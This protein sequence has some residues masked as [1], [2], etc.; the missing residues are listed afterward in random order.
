MAPKRSPKKAV[1]KTAASSRPRRNAPR[2]QRYGFE[3]SRPRQPHPGAPSSKNTYIP[4]SSATKTKVAKNGYKKGTPTRKSSTSGKKESTPI[5]KERSPTKSSSPFAVPR[6]FGP[7]GPTPSTSPPKSASPRKDSPRIKRESTPIKKESS[8]SSTPRSASAKDRTPSVE[9]KR[10]ASK[11]HSP[12]KSKSPTIPTTARFFFA[13]ASPVFS[14]WSPR[15]DESAANGSPPACAPRDRNVHTAPNIRHDMWAP[16]T[17]AQW[18][19]N[20]GARFVDGSPDFEARPED[21]REMQ[22]NRA[23]NEDGADTQLMMRCFVRAID[24]NEAWRNWV[25]YF[26]LR[27][28][29][30][31]PEQATGH[32]QGHECLRDDTIWHKRFDPIW[33]KYGEGEDDE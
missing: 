14:P 28:C 18:L 19:Q 22:Y 33:K 1:V 11:S 7:F 32:E 29:G 10:E 30:C 24:E 31:P 15:S 5:A 16:W 25:D 17:R 26:G 9:I 3:T 4:T 13:P 21:W 12:G 27:Y 20:H 6:N 23:I 2:P 8:R